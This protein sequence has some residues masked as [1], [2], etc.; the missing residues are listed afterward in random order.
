MDLPL[1]NLKGAVVGTIEVS[2]AVFDVPFRPTLVHQV[3]VGHLANRRV[4]TH[5][6]K[7]RAEVRGGGRKPWRQKG[8][9][10]ARQGSIRSPQWRGGGV[11]FGPKPRDY[12]HHTP[13]KMRQEA[14]RCLLAQKVRDEMV[15]VVEEFDLTDAKTKDAIRTLADLGIGAKCLVVSGEPAPDLARAYRN[16]RRVKSLPAYTLNTLDLLNYDHLLM[17]VGAVRKVEALW[18]KRQPEPQPLATEPGGAPE[19]GAAAD[20]DQA[21]GAAES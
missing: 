6:T 16:L 20:A 17:S 15:T 4:G 8:T 13:R 1:K 2:D 9:G 12:H 21:E 5:S 7:T 19:N 18:D 10:R 11:V 3:M 14:I